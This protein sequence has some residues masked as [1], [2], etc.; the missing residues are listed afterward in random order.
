MSFANLLPAPRG[1]RRIPRLRS[2]LSLPSTPRLRSVL[3]L[4]SILSLRSP[5]P[6]TI[7]LPA[8]ILS[9]RRHAPPRLSLRLPSRLLRYRSRGRAPWHWC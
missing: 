7:S 1:R 3:S 9:V 4:P 5:P 2:I 6:V 8:R